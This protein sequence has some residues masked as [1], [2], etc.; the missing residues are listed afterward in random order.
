MQNIVNAD[1]IVKV[2]HMLSSKAKKGWSAATSPLSSPVTLLPPLFSTSLTPE[3]HITYCYCTW[4]F[5]ENSTANSTTSHSHLHKLWW[6]CKIF[7]ITTCIDVLQLSQACP[8]N[9]LHSIVAWILTYLPHT[10]VCGYWSMEGTWCC[11]QS[12]QAR[13]SRWSWTTVD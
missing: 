10:A 6:M 5:S 7:K 1:W 11:Y 13:Q 3:C 12:N 2:R 4:T 9:M 8:H